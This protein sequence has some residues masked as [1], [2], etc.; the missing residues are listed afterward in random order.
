[1]KTVLG[2]IKAV[3]LI[4]LVCF[5]FAFSETRNKNRNLND[6]TVTFTEGEN[7]YVTE[8]AVN[9][10]LIQNKQAISSIDKETLDLNKAENLL[11]NHDMIDNAEVFVTLDGKLAAKVSQRKPIGR[12][13]GET[14]FY[15]D[16]DGEVM[17]LSSNYS[18]RVPLMT[19]FSE[20]NVSSA[21]KVIQFIQNDD[22]LRKMIVMVERNT[23]GDL[24]L[25]LREND[26][27]VEFGDSTNLALKF[28]NLKA[29]YKKALKDN[30]LEDY[31][32]VNLQFGDQV[33]C[34]KK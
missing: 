22:F 8:D 25:Q 21:F 16:E 13:Y 17:P 20:Q 14:S 23:S 26:F 19:G 4:A 5:L 30:K 9:K 29:F 18:A 28:H 3:G 6:L 32:K 2:Y 11:N 24:E 34:T 27:L 12:V 33:V 7:L 10:L 1:M 15:L 31:S